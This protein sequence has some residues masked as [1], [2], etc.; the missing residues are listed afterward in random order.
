MSSDDN[1]CYGDWLER[2]SNFNQLKCDLEQIDSRLRDIYEAVYFGLRSSDE[3]RR[4]LINQGFLAGSNNAHELSSLMRSILSTL[5]ICMVLL[6]IIAIKIV[7][8]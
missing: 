7:F 2:R 3:D 8:F 5:R 6:L 1:D 4:R